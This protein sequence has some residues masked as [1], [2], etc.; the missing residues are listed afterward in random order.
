[1]ELPPP[2]NIHLLQIPELFF[3]LYVL[4]ATLKKYHN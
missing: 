4:Y 3:L 1:M 2:N